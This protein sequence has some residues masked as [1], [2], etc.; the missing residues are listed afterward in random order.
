MRHLKLH[1]A[2]HTAAT[3][4]HLDGVRVAVIAAWIG[5]KDASRTMKLYAHSQDDAL[6]LAATAVD[7]CNIERNTEVAGDSESTIAAVHRGADD[8]NEPAYSAW[9]VSST[10]EQVS[11]SRW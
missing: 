3:L 7:Y 11:D 10:P 9:E 2:R 1:G 5:H 4:L 8:G 6:K